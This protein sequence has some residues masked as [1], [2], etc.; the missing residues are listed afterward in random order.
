[1]IKIGKE[2]NLEIGISG[3]FPICIFPQEEQEQVI[4]LSANICD[5]GLNQLVISSAGDIKACVCLPQILGNILDDNPKDV[6]RNS[7]FLQSLRRFEHVPKQCYK[8]DLVSMCKGGCRAAAYCTYGNFKE[9][10]PIIEEQ[11]EIKCQEKIEHTSFA[12]PV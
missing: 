6:W 3:G 12:I 2:R 11:G 1:M 9:I 5:A 8:C 7:P 10:D 4:S